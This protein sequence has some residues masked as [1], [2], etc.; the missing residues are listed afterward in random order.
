MRLQFFT[1]TLL[2]N[3]VQPHVI[4]ILIDPISIPFSNAPLMPNA[5]LDNLN[6]PKG[7]VMST[8]RN[9][10]LHDEALCIATE[11]LYRVSQEK[12]LMA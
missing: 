3:H 5:P 6:A 9:T 2:G 7:A 8:L 4:K 1:L 12:Q 10:G 11:I